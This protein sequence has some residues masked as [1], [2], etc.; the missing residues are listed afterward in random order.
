MVGER[1]VRVMR[2][3]AILALVMGLGFGAARADAVLIKMATLVP[4][5]SEWTQILQKMVEEWRTLSNGQVTVRIYPGGVAGDD[6]DVV[7][8]MRLGT[9]NAGLL[10]ST[11]LEDLDRGILAL[12]IPLAYA[13]ATSA[14]L[15]TQGIWLALAAGNLFN[16]LSLGAWFL[17]GRWKL[18][19]V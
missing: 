16:G 2:S 7:R 9:L 3:V 12:Q 8:K 14:G 17:R 18:H 10:T 15:G 5:G 19:K 11:G 1:E 4:Q 13:L 6:T